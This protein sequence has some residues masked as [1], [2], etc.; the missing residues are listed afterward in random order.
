VKRADQQRRRLMLAALASSMASVT[1]PAHTAG[2]ELRFA[3]L[4]Q[5]LDELDSMAE[6]AARD[7]A[8]T[9]SWAETLEHCAQSIEYSIVGYPQTKSPLFQRSLGAIAFRVF[10]MRGYMSHNLREPIPGAPSYRA[11]TSTRTAVVRLRAAIRGFQTCEDALFPH[12]AYG[13]LSKVE[14]EQ[15]HLMHLAEHFAEF[16]AKP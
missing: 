10:A 8:A 3:S 6:A 14:Y 9:W 12:F 2:R 16:V 15:A 13:V 7:T 1:G 5:A 4:G 11:S